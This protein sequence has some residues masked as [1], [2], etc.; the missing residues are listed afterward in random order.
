MCA[1]ANIYV[2]LH[3][4]ASNLIFLIIWL[5][6]S[7]LI[8][9]FVWCF[10]LPPLCMFRSLPRARCSNRPGSEILTA[11]L[12]DTKL[13]R[14]L[15]FT[16]KWVWLNG[17]C[18]YWAGATRSWSSNANIFKEKV[19]WH[20]MDFTESPLLSNN[21]KLLNN[22]ILFLQRFQNYISF[23]KL[24]SRSGFNNQMIKIDSKIKDLCLQT[25]LK[26]WIQGS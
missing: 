6:L 18:Q 25:R 24:G 9:L 19:E 2:F 26:T 17:S 12:F 21:P 3:A 22:C 14:R 15:V 7:F 5:Q 10:W 13:Y 1:C 23:C 20:Q 11:D 8:I 16:K 4:W